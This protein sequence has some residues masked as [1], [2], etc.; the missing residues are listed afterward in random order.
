VLT[1]LAFLLVWFALVGPDEISRLSLTA[2]L[3]IPV[4][5]LVLVAV[6]VVLPR[7][8]RNVT[9]AVVG[10][11]LALLTIVKILDM[12]FLVALG[13]TFNPVIDVTYLDSGVSLLNDSVGR[14]EAVLV[15]VAAGLLI[16]ALLVL[17]PLAVVRLAR[18]VSRHR[19]GSLRAV[20]ALGVVWALCAVTGLHLASAH[21]T[22]LVYGRMRQIPADIRDQHAF[23]KAAA[24]DPLR[25]TPPS[26]LFTGLRGKDVL[27]VFVESYGRVAVEGSNFSPAVDSVL[28]AGTRR[29][30]ADGFASRSAWLTSP[31]FGAVS[32]LAHSTLQSGLWVSNQQRYDVLVASKRQT[33]SDAFHR[34]GWRTVGDVPSNNRPW[35]QGAF[36]NYDKRYDSRNVGYA[37]PK[38]SYA[39]MPDQYTLAAFRRKELAKPHPPVMAEIDLVSSHAPWTP[40][41][42]MVPWNE[43]GNG[44]VYDPMPAQG[45]APDAVWPDPGRVQAV[46]G[47]SIQYTMSSLI[48]FLHT[49]HDKNLVLVVLGDHQP[50]TIVS[51][52][53]ASHDVPISIVAHDP[54]VM[55]RI[56]GWGWQHGLRPGAHAP[57]W[58]MDA[59]RDRFLSAYG[60]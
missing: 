21:A 37:G 43:V 40:L 39:A 10:V 49:Y 36:Y 59:F 15:L 22:H 29:L 11:V 34:A 27:V 32:W 54:A 50:A 48:S 55:N 3:R 5:G 51:G 31:T 23:A 20:T 28:D 4:E 1:V 9:A 8:A 35:P 16:V 18:L 19:T 7:R 58:P 13:R 26:R 57:V 60:R 53:H 2:F 38:F 41:P 17:M 25:D 6:V 47:Q 33:L 46:Y 42:H 30:D 24:V 44:S 12:G 14:P 52:E 45:K 56:S